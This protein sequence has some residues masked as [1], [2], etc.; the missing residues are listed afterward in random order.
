MPER[1]TVLN[2]GEESAEAIVCAGQRV[3]PEG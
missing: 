3:V 1:A 2:R